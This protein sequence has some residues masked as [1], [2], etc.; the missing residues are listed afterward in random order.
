[1]IE[2][3]TKASKPAEPDRRSARVSRP[4][5]PPLPAHEADD[6]M[7]AC[8]AAGNMSMQSLFC[9]GAIQAKLTIGRPDDIYEQEADEVAERVMRSAA[10]PPIQRKCAACA[11][12]V[13]CSECEHEER[14]QAKEAGGRVSRVPATAEASIASLRGG[15][16]PLPTS[17][18]AFFEPRFRQDFGGVRVHTD[19]AAAATARSIQARA[20]T[21]IP[22]VVFAAG[23]YNPNTTEG[24]RLLAHELTHVVQQMSGGSPAVQMETAPQPSHDRLCNEEGRPNNPANPIPFPKEGEIVCNYEERCW[25]IECTWP[26]KG[27]QECCW[28]PYVPARPPISPDG[29][30]EGDVRCEAK[31]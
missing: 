19:G 2:V 26:D 22:D 5:S 3:K 23:E 18:R 8:S 25:K 31:R 4:Q 6:V 1:M 9:S 14:A 17:L 15:G 13:P 16:R 30:R 20:F 7:D 11:N 12:G 21:A 24:R 29:Y 27:D 10:V 28:K